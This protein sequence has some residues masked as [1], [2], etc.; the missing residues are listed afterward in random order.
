[1]DAR[2]NPFAAPAEMDMGPVMQF[3]PGLTHVVL[4]TRGLPSAP[5]AQQYY[6]A[7]H[8]PTTS[9]PGIFSTQGSARPASDAT[10]AAARASAALNPPFS[11]EH[12]AKRYT[13]HSKVLQLAKAKAL[14]WIDH[15]NKERTAAGRSPTAKEDRKDKYT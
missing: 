2:D 12:A 5:G 10:I 6:D 11:P 15:I 13:T 8:L 7:A 14:L 1:M 9:R 3:A 4:S